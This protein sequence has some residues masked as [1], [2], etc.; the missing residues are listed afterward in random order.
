MNTMKMPVI[1][2]RN[3]V[4]AAAMTFCFGNVKK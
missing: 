1:M 3:L 2:A 4:Y